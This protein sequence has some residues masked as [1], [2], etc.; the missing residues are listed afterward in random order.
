[1]ETYVDF[2]KKIYMTRKTLNPSYSLVC[3]SRDAGF[4]S[5]H[6]YDVFIGRYG[7]SP[8]RAKDVA[9]SLKL[10]EKQSL[11][12]VLLVTSETAR[13]PRDRK[14]AQQKLNEILN[15]DSEF[16][17][18]EAFKVMSEWHYLAIMVMTHHPEA[19]SNP[20]WYAKRLGLSQD[21]VKRAIDKLQHLEL[22]RKDSKGF[23][24]TQKRRFEVYATNMPSQSIQAYHSEIIQKAL[25]SVMSADPETRFLNSHTLFLDKASY[26]DVVSEIKEFT[27]DLI[28]RYA[29]QE[30]PVKSKIHALALQLF[31]LEK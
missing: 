14:F 19:Q 5:N 2:L 15:S 26:K 27:T 7:L 11:H 28:K 25:N 12:F 24:K 18:E 3:F 16:L 1:M 30:V 9:K 31:P 4:S 20:D 10:T 22:I 29:S 23:Y 13:S 21:V 8:K 6:I 17:S